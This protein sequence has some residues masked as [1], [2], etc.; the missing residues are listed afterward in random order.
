MK[1]G[2]KILIQQ[3]CS[4]MIFENICMTCVFLNKWIL[5][6]I[7]KTVSKNKIIKKNS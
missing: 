5:F 1:H 4:L 6:I 7:T 2:L 3:K